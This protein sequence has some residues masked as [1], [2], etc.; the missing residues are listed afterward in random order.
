MFFSS[1]I[2]S[3]FKNV[4]FP[5]N[6]FSLKYYHV[7]CQSVLRC[8]YRCVPPILFSYLWVKAERRLK[9]L[10]LFYYSYFLFQFKCRVSSDKKIV[11]FASF[12]VMTFEKAIVILWWNACL[13]YVDWLKCFTSQHLNER[14]IDIYK[15]V[16]KLKYS[17]ITWFAS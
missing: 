2:I 13:W 5:Q 9:H 11:C 10:S 17:S 6:T 14:I 15:T 1:F 3:L 4:P 12:E 8:N 7:H 16:R